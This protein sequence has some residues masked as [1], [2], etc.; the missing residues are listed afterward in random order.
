[1]KYRNNEGPV[2][3][4]NLHYR[5]TLWL[6][7]FGL[8]HGFIIRAGDILASYAITGLLIYWFA[9][10]SVRLLLMMAA[11]CYLLPLLAQIGL[12]VLAPPEFI[13]EFRKF[14]D[15]S[16]ITIQLESNAY[17]GTWIEGTRPRSFMTV[18]QLTQAI[19]MGG[20]F[21]LAATMFLGM[22]LFKS[23]V[24]SGQRERLFYWKGLAWGFGIGFSLV[25]ISA[26]RRLQSDFAF[27]ENY[28]LILNYIGAPF[29]AFGYICA[30]ILLLRTASESRFGKAIIAVGRMAFTN[31]IM[32]SVICTFIFYGTG[33]GLHGQIE[34]SGQLVIAI[35]VWALQLIVSPWW[36]SRYR[37]GPLEWLWRGL[38]YR[39]WPP[40]KQPT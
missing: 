31:Y 32:Q 29:V 5:R 38:S 23:G 7:I 25:L 17:L 8:I 11:I 33:L 37:Y 34:R 35:G 20:I 28:L 14:W 12:F 26:L 27:S 22:A 10:K 13:E 39:H 4:R 24:L 40:F 21:R 2:A 6:L 9:S 1:M 16:D 19:F 15:P 30:A 18:Q 36:L 3:A